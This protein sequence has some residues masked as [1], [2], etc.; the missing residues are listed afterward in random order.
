MGKRGVVSVRRADE[1]KQELARRIAHICREA[2]DEGNEHDTLERL[3]VLCESLGQEKP[4]GKT[5]FTEE[6]V[7]RMGAER[8]IAALNLGDRMTPAQ[9]VVTVMNQEA[10]L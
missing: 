5:E 9:L 3:A 8:I 10:K 6:D 2:L 4:N 7:L 1:T